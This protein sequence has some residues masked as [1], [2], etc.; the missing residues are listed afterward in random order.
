MEVSGRVKALNGKPVV[1]GKVTLFS[2][3]GDVFLMDT[4]T[5]V[6]GEFNF[7]NL[8]FSDSTKFI[9][10]AR[11]E[12]DRKN[13]EIELNRI[14]PQLVTKN[15]NEAML[16]VNVNR[17]ILPYLQ[18]SKNQYDQFR[19]FGVVGRSIML[20]EVKVVEKK[21][22][23]KNSAN[24][25]G[26]GNADAILKS[27]DFQNC[28]FLSQCLQGRVAGI[29]VNNGIVYSTRSMNS[30]F[31]GPVPMQIVIDGMMVEP[32]FISSVNPND[33]ES[34]EVLKSGANTAIYG[35]R[36]G[37]GVLIINTKRAEVNRDYRTYAPGIVSYNPKGFYKGRDFYSPN[38]DDPKVNT[39][40][41]DLR[42]TIY[43]NPNVISDSTG[44]ASIEFF[45]ADGTGNYK[46]IIE[47]VD[48]NGKLGRQI[49]RYSVK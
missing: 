10:Q 21:P 49:Y 33:V 34:I 29:I 9:V 43:W 17:S 39:K 45:N 20:A 7:Q 11:N 8:T 26:A 6:N 27:E 18:N 36:G 25:N 4:L 15:K 28:V 5:D 14:P 35:M 2:S 40:M 37:G 13:V 42:T 22:V 19:L 48:I 31:R 44:K 23:L 30:S 41:A 47:G 38:Y 16:E 12:K 24:L 46:A 3:T 32:E 1:G